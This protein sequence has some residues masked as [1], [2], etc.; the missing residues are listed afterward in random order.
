MEGISVGFLAMARAGY[1]G[2]NSADLVAAIRAGVTALRSF[3]PLCVS[4]Q[5][6]GAHER[7]SVAQLFVANLPLYSYGLGSPRSPIRATGSSISRQ[8]KPA[9]AVR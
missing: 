2:R 5:A 8:S 6:T 3:D 9:A 7:M 4:I 1:H